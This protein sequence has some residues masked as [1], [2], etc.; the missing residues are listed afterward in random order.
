MSK[1]RKDGR[2]LILKFTS[3]ESPVLDEV[4]FRS[5]ESVAFK[6]LPRCGTK[7]YFRWDKFPQ[8]FSLFFLGYLIAAKTE[9]G[10]PYRF[11]GKRRNSAVA[12]LGDG[13]HQT[14]TAF[15]ALFEG[16]LRCV[17]AGDNDNGKANRDRRIWL[18]QAEDLPPDCVEVIWEPRGES[19]LTEVADLRMLAGGIQRQTNWTE[20]ALET[21]AFTSATVPSGTAGLQE[22]QL[23]LVKPAATA[24]EIPAEIKENLNRGGK[25]I[26]EEKYSEAQAIYES[27][28]KKAEAAR[29]A[30]AQF[31]ARV[32]LAEAI[33]HQNGELERVREI[34]MACESQLKDTPDDTQRITVCYLMTN[35]EMAEDRINEARSLYLETLKLARGRKDR[36]YE[37][38]LLIG[39]AHAEE[40]LGNLSE[41]QRLLDQAAD[42]FRAEYRASAG[43][44]R[45][46]AA[47]NLGGCY[48]LKS[49]VYR[50]EAKLLDSLRF[51]A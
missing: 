29:N 25:L 23:V 41:A 4:R 43:E 39:V 21:R 36:S 28:L 8:V 46:K 44:D 37:G 50:H 13:I 16:G 40:M 17:F 20:L 33:L 31:K 6:V 32:G 38:L 30:R 7:N 47:V 3:E 42:L 35:V 10:K 19:P 15:H 51:A 45:K 27:A 14:T 22:S 11:A 5:R 34:L 18:R 24:E 1:A 9:A 26:G 12:T 48:V 2:R 49:A